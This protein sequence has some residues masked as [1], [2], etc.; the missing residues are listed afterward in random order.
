MRPYLEKLPYEPGSSICVLD[1]RLDEGIP[2]QWH[3]HP[4]YELTLTLNSRGQRF[5]G[6]HVG[7][8]DHCDLV[9]V[10]PNLPHTWASSSRHDDKS[11]HIAMVIWFHPDWVRR[12]TSC[13]AE[14]ER[15][16]VFLNRA[17]RGLHFSSVLARNMQSSIE[18]LFEAGAQE[19]VFCLLR[20]L[21][22]LSHDGEALPLASTG[23]IRDH[24]GESQERISRVLAFIH[25]NYSEGVPLE[26]LADVAALSISGV[27][28]LF[29]KH[30]STTIS[31]YIMQL[32][33]GDACSRLSSTDQQISSIAHDVGYQS[34]ANFNRQ[35][36][37]SKKMTPREYRAHFRV[38]I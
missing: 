9:L 15:L 1:R 30:V 10:G 14:F 8:Y 19:R 33:I 2:F 37:A 35:F 20:L 32:R 24:A 22:Q 34:L 29:Q 12:I 7:E 13:F 27:H 26:E 11:P 31:A 25:D 16:E 36:K 4:E 28:R 5:I 23:V 21:E 18:R 17:V 3:H 6:D 38:T